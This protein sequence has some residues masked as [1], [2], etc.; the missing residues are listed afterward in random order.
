MQRNNEQENSDQ[1]F[2][3]K[4]THC[5]DYDHNW[6]NS[7]KYS[8]NSKVYKANKKLEEK[9]NFAMDEDSSSDREIEGRNH[10]CLKNHSASRLVNLL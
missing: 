10:F 5:K 7:P 2:K 1:L 3:N 9:E 6:Y 4:Y 8:V